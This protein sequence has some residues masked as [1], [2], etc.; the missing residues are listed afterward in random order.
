VN[1][2]LV[3]QVTTYTTQPTKDINIHA[4]SMIQIHSRKNEVPADLCLRPQG[5]WDRPGFIY[6]HLFP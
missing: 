3:A 1:Y 5:H 4:L 6:L 2:Q